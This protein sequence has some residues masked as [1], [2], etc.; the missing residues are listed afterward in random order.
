MIEC[1]PN[2]RSACAP[3][4]PGIAPTHERR[5]HPTEH[6]KGGTGGTKRKHTRS[7]GEDYEGK[8]TVKRAAARHDVYF[9]AQVHETYMCALLFYTTFRLQVHRAFVLILK[10]QR[11]KR[12]NHVTKLAYARN[13]NTHKE[14]EGWGW[15]IVILHTT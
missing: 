5:Y 14:V 15:R 10:I 9:V 13:R 7:R 3:S 2:H 8:V 11:L 12:A 4:C 6:L 1:S